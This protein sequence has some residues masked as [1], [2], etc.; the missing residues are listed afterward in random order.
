[1]PPYPQGYRNRRYEIR[2][3]GKD[4]I[5]QVVGRVSTLENAEIAAEERRRDPQN[6]EVWVVDREEEAARIAKPRGRRKP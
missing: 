3:R 4:G 5:G 2:V 6:V 1:M